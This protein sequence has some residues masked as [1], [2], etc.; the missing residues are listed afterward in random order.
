MIKWVDSLVRGLRS[1]T[2]VNAYYRAIDKFM[3]RGEV[4]Q[5]VLLAR[6]VEEQPHIGVEPW[7]LEA[8]SNR[9]VRALALS[10]S[11]D[12]ASAAL[13]LGLSSRKQSTQRAL[14][15][16]AVSRDL[17]SLLATGQSKATLLALLEQLQLQPEFEEVLVCW[18]QERVVRGDDFSDEPS[19]CRLWSQLRE[20][21]H[22]LACLPL[23]LE[24]L[25]TELKNW[26][27][28]ES[29]GGSSC[30]M[31]YGTAER[32]DAPAPGLLEEVVIT[33]LQATGN[34]ASVVA[35][36]EEESNG[37]SEARTFRF[38]PATRSSMVSAA[39][40]KSLPLICLNGS[41]VEDVV[42]R[43]VPTAQ[44]VSIL[45][46]ASAN[47]GAYNRGRRAAYGRLELWRS[48]AALVRHQ[49]VEFGSLAEKVAKWSW[50]SFDAG[51]DWFEHVAWDLGIAALSPDATE[52]S[53]LAATDTD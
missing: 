7:A 41:S 53:I 18:V 34:I 22:P 30:G 16:Q 32:T 4:A 10:D 2:D 1:A 45:F 48:V 28:K 8:V 39:F 36:W 3:E 9:A 19:V 25:E 31:P 29:V 37:R 46:A 50:Y 12:A 47:G 13:H 11:L 24:R 44:A 23:R 52:M 27:R 33:E 21:A 14:A 15:R 49:G 43:P 38:E 35:N 26:L 42:I 20:S 51:G 5:A 40:M 17:A 6:A